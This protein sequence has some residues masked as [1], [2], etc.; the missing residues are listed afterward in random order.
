MVATGT[1]GLGPECGAPTPHLTLNASSS[2]TTLPWNPL[3]T[4]SASSIAIDPEHPEIL[5]VSNASRIAR[6]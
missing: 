5:Y 6:S 1:S 2:W 4:G 3:Q